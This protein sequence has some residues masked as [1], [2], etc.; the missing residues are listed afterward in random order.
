MSD[1]KLGQ[2]YLALC[3]EAGVEP[4]RTGLRDL[5]GF[6]CTSMGVPQ[7]LW[8]ERRSP[9]FTDPASLGVLVSVVREV[10]GT[11]NLYCEPCSWDGSQPTGWAV[12]DAYLEVQ[13]FGTGDTE[14]GAWIG[15]L[16]AYPQE[17][18]NGGGE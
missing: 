18:H 14:A 7:P 12:N 1:Q 10:W 8:W 15:A 13:C 2:R 9:T 4:W 11:P 6:R 5:S 16:E 17:N 3:K